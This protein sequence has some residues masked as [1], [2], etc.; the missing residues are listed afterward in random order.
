MAPKKELSKDTR[1]Q[2][3]TLKNEG[4]THRQ[5]SGKLGVSVGVVSNTIKRL[6]ETTSYENRPRSGR[7]RI[8]TPRDDRKL[9][10]LVRKDRKL[11]S[12]ELAGLWIL[13]SGIKASPRTVRSRLF[14]ANYQYKSAVR[15]P[16]LTKKHKKARLDFCKRFESLPVEVWRK[17]IFSDEMNIEVDNR[18]G[19]VKIRR[20]PSEKYHPSC[21][22][23][24]TRQGSGSIGIWA[25]MTPNNLGIVHTFDGRLN[26][27]RYKE[28]LENCLIP[29]IESKCDPDDVVFQQDNAPC[30]RAKSVQEWFDDHEIAVLD[31]PAN[32]PDLNPIENLWAWLDKQIA[33]LAPQDKDQLE[34]MVHQSLSNV[35]QEI[36]D[37]LYKSMPNRLQECIKNRGGATSY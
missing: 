1:V 35:P 3:V 37:N 10:N 2:I 5:I 29:T 14:E 31:W 18:K 17:V 15:K 19:P 9:L 13:A 20:L 16:R 24:R 7:P 6:K 28:I 21:I 32:S 4:Y 33:K 11:S 36:I 12:T 30:H 25:C 34:E 23:E 8:S 27:H 22:V 26:Q